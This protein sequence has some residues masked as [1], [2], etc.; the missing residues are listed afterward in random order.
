MDS[1]PGQHTPDQPAAAIDAP[2][3][4]TEDLRRPTTRIPIRR[5]PTIQLRKRRTRSRILQV[6]ERVA[7]SAALISLT[8]LIVT[9]FGLLFTG[10]QYF[11]EQERIAN[12][13]PQV[14]VLASLEEVGK[15][16]SLTAI[17]ATVSVHNPGQQRVT[18]ASAIYNIVGAT[19]IPQD[20]SDAQYQ[21][22]ADALFQSNFYSWFARHVGQDPWTPIQSGHLLDHR[23]TTWLDP[24]DALEFVFVF[25]VPSDT[26]DNI[27]IIT[28]INIARGQVIVWPPKNEIPPQNRQQ[29]STP[30]SSPSEQPANDQ[31]QPSEDEFTIRMGWK[32]SGGYMTAVM[33]VWKEDQWVQFSC[34]ERDKSCQEEHTM[35]AH[36]HGLYATI[37]FNSLSLW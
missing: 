15:K 10:Y 4:S 25:Y 14:S 20:L 24:D 32:M 30:G 9:A 28:A 11:R 19:V 8:T 5:R 17:E 37:R 23:S 33:E 26:Y 27:A 13:P 21:A 2:P 18:L 31:Q 6:V 12:L 34:P 36:R 22:Q 1:S 7:R 3:S 35:L 29:P 16:D